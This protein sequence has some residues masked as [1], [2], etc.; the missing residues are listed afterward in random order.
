MSLLPSTWLCSAI[1]G[2]LPFSILVTGPNHVSFLFLILSTIVSFCSIF[3]RII[4]LRF[5][6]RLDFP[7]IPLSQII[8]ATSSSLSSSLLRQKHSEP[9]SRTGITSVLYNFFFVLIDILFYLHIFLSPPNIAEARLFL[10]L[11]SFV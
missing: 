1:I 11:I 10:L 7:S 6:S 2:S 4:S 5:L 8:Y 3:W 9:C